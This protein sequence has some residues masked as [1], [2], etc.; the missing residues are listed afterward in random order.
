[1]SRGRSVDLGGMQTMVLV[2]VPELMVVV[3][4]VSVDEIVVLEV[5]VAGAAGLKE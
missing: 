1:M 4:V 2:I 5:I 3:V